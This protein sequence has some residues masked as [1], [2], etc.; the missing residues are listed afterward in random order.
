ML[1]A[2]FL[3]IIFCILLIS[4]TT[5]FA[6]EENFLLKNGLTNEIIFETG[7]HLD[8][9]ISPC[10]S[11]KIFLSLMGYDSGILKDEVTPTW[12]FQDG[13]DDYLESWKVP[14]NPRNW[15]KHSCLW[16][17]KNIAQDLGLK[18]IENY[19]DLMEYGNKD[20]SGGFHPPEPLGVAWICSSLKIS[21]R[22]Q[23]DFIQD[24]VLGKL[25]FSLKAV[26]MTKNLIYIEELQGGWKLFGKTGWSGH[27]ICKDGITLEH[28]WFVGWIEKDGQFYPFAYLIKENQINL[29]QRIP[30]V[31]Q[32]LEKF[33]KL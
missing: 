15:M 27:D 5:L 20:M 2:L 4:S 19:L 10:S 22:E 30:R 25:A 12:N 32:L 13:Y 9:R 31:K 8:E 6:A 16:Y 24:M 18:K 3:R 1:H 26:E 21:P 17:S 28:G 14:L 33:L 7:P 29:P 11:F 23:V